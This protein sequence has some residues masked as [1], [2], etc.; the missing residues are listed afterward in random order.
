[1]FPAGFGKTAFLR[2]LPFRSPA[3]SGGVMISETN[4]SLAGFR[5]ISFDLGV[6]VNKAVLLKSSLLPCDDGCLK[7][8]DISL[9]FE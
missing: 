2:S 4:G 1:M 8:S 6:V 9:S 7:F 5:I 3:K